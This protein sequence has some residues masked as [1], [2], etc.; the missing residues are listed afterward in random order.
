M[1]LTTIP[2]NPSRLEI[3]VISASK[4]DLRT[5]VSIDSHSLPRSFQREFES[6]TD[7]DIPTLPNPLPI[8]IDVRHQCQDSLKLQKIDSPA[9][10][11]TFDSLYYGHSYNDCS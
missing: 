8:C 6:S 1:Y 10:L 3:C 4:L 9:P 5:D 11:D 7:I 2:C